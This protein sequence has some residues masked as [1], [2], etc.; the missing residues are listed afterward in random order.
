VEFVTMTC[1]VTT[2]LWF[3]LHLVLTRLPRILVSRP[4]VSITSH[5]TYTKEVFYVKAKKAICNPA[6][7]SVCVPVCKK[8]HPLTSQA[9]I[10]SA[11]RTQSF[12]VTDI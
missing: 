10:S 5:A 6:V 9:I 3:V 1:F 7:T 4:L 8:P 12:P 2:L 11:K